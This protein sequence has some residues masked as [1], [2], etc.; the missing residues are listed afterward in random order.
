MFM[1]MG[2]KSRW[3]SARELAKASQNRDRA[4]KSSSATAYNSDRSKRKQQEI[5]GASLSPS[6]SLSR[7]V[8]DKLINYKRKTSTSI[9]HKIHF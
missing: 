9:N 4:K 7:W 5:L 8:C 1:D 3:D 6:L 2:Q